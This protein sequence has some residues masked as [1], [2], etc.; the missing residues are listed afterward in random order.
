MAASRDDS[1]NGF[2]HVRALAVTHAKLNINNFPS[3]VS[4]PGLN[5]CQ[6]QFIATDKATTHLNPSM[7]P[8]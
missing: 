1:P 8:P 5:V 2:I 6:V 3:F 7:A 4:H